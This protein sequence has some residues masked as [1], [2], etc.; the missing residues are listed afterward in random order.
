[1]NDMEVFL[2]SEIGELFLG[3]VQEITHAIPSNLNEVKNELQVILIDIV[4]TIAS[5][6]AGGF[7]M[8]LK[9]EL[10]QPTGA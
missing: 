10:R 3:T 1:M 5:Q 2:V 6:Q 4:S 8:P 7:S 9:I